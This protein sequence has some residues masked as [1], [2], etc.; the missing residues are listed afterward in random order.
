MRMNGRQRSIMNL[1]QA[2]LVLEEAEEQVEVLPSRQNKLKMTEAYGIYRDLEAVA[3]KNI[4]NIDELER[5]VAM[6]VMFLQS[7]NTL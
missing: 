7:I 2:A 5:C 6:G 1:V 4:S 3:I